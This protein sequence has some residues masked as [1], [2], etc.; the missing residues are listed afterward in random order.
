MDSGDLAN[1][2][3]DLYEKL[4]KEVSETGKTVSS[5]QYLIDSQTQMNHAIQL[6]QS[7]YI[8]SN[9]EDFLNI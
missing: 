9:Y 4:E 3:V 5:K 8:R 1:M 2:L 7:L 6:I